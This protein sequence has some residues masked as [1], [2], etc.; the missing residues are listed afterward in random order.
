MNNE[1]IAYINSNPFTNTDNIPKLDNDDKEL[2]DIEISIEDC[3][4]ALK[5]TP[6]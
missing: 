4:K 1:D 2:C 6:K 3:A 5:K